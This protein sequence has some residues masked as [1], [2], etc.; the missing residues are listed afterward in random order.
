MSHIYIF[1]DKLSVEGLPNVKLGEFNRL[2]SPVTSHHSALQ[3]VVEKASRD[4]V[5]FVVTG[6]QGQL[7]NSGSSLVTVLVRHFGFNEENFVGQIKYCLA[8]IDFSWDKVVL[9][10]GDHIF[11]LVLRNAYELLAYGEHV[12][13]NPG[14][15]FDIRHWRVIEETLPTWARKKLSVRHSENSYNKDVVLKI[16]D[17]TFVTVVTKTRGVNVDY[18]NEEPFCHEEV[19][20]VTKEDRNKIIYKTPEYNA[21]NYYAEEKVTRLHVSRSGKSIVVTTNEYD[22]DEAGYQASTGVD[23]HPILFSEILK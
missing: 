23:L 4:E 7:L 16:D 8:A 11:S 13:V 14:N 12:N 10:P 15:V 9:K 21:F 22:I 1:L 6:T 20:L 5:T 18:W 3:S 19:T 2:E 17:D